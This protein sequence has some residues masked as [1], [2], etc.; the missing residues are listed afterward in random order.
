MTLTARLHS[1]RPLT[2]PHSS[3]SSKDCLFLEQRRA[4]KLFGLVVAALS[5]RAWT[6]TYWLDCLPHAFAIVWHSDVG[7]A[8]SGFERLEHM[9]A[10]IVRANDMV[11]KNPRF[12]P[13]VKGTLSLGDS[14][15]TGDAVCSC[16]A[17][18]VDLCL[19]VK[20]VVGDFEISAMLS[21]RT[22]GSHRSERYPTKCTEQSINDGVAFQYNNTQVPHRPS[23][24]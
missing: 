22:G 23:H 14:K 6:M 20:H 4:E 24:G 15:P 8:K 13:G 18:I 1:S 2:C 11:S 21:V 19:S 17:Q 3:A 10:A 7:I 12:A 5:Q 9:W 16:R